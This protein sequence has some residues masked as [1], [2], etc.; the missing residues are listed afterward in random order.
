MDMPGVDMT[1]AKNQDYLQLTDDEKKAFKDSLDNQRRIARYEKRQAAD[2]FSIYV[3]S[4][5]CEDTIGS[6]QSRC[7]Q[8]SYLKEDFSICSSI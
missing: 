1:R 7:E 5:C 4:Y 3:D 6:L 8:D 2:A